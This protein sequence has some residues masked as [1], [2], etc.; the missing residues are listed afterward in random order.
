MKK[1][2]DRDFVKKNTSS[3]VSELDKELFFFECKEGNSGDESKE[4]VA[5]KVTSWSL[6][7]N[8]EHYPSEKL[9]KDSLDEKEDSSNKVT[10]WI[11]AVDDVQYP[12]DNLLGIL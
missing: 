1:M 2:V 3:A 4:E 7:V 6:P 12:S 9:V 11:N 10:G 8:D 5:N